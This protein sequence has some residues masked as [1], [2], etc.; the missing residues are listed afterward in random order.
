M[1]WIRGQS[2]R[3]IIGADAGVGDGRSQRIGGCAGV[4]AAAWEALRM[5]YTAT[6]PEHGAAVEHEGR[7][8]YVSATKRNFPPVATAKRKDSRRV[9]GVLRIN[10]AVASDGELHDRVVV[11]VHNVESR[12]YRATRLRPPDYVHPK[13]KAKSE[14]CAC[15]RTPS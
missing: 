3:P 7:G 11:L 1:C 13:G 6:D 8:W 4:R 9:H 5:G 2:K 12:H 15:G 14:W 10:L